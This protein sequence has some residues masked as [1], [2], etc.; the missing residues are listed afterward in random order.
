MNSTSCSSCNQEA[1]ISAEIIGYKCPHEGKWVE[2]EMKKNNKP[3]ICNQGTEL[4]E[5]VLWLP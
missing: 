2:R 1:A 4:P 5:L 3:K